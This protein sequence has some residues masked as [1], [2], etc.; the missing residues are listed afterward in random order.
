MNLDMLKRIAAP[1]T[2][3]LTVALA[4][5][6]CNRKA[7]YSH[8]EHTPI[9][10]WEKNDHLFFQTS[11]FA[12]EGRY[13]EVVGLRIN[14]SYP[15]RGLTLIVEQH[16]EPSGLRRTDTLWCKLID[17]NGVV[18]GKGISYFQYNFHLC[19]IPLH[20]GDSLHVELRHNMK[21]EMLPGISDVGISL[22]RI[23]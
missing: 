5:A 20:K 8:Y 15:F 12:V 16:V 9:F 7:V 11:P 19:D 10:G 17:A 23:D 13:R 3:L 6:S 22:E 1:L 4:F 21:R 18:Q 2:I 14:S